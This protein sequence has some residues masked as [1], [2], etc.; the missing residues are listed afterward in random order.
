MNIRKGL[1]HG[2]ASCNAKGCNWSCEDYLTIQQKAA[3]HAEH[4]GHVVVAE[5]GYVVEYGSKAPKVVVRRAM[6]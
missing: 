4:T 2:V 5:L 1:V 3:Y 6:P